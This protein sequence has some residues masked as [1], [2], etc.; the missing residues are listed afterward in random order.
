MGS[1]HL[2]RKQS[3]EKKGHRGTRC[4][5]L[6]IALQEKAPH[7]DSL[8]SKWRGLGLGVLSLQGPSLWGLLTVGASLLLATPNSIAK[9][10]VLHGVFVFYYKG[11]KTK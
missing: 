6:P 4:G 5:G 11:L 7:P 8:L 9:A 2:F 10:A 1:M 3:L